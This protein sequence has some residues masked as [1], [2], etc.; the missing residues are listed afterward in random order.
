MPNSPNRLSQ[1]WQELKRRKV[2][3]VIAM[4]AATA[5]IIMEAAEI[6]LP[7]FGLP[8]WTVTFIIILLIVGFLITIIFSWIFDITPEGIKKTEPVEVVKETAI[9]PAK[10]RFRPS[11]VI[12]ALLVVIVVILAYPK[13]FKKDKSLF[14]KAFENKISIAVFPF[15][16]N[17]GDSA[18]DHLENGISE[19]LI[20]ALS[21]SD[22]LSVIDN[23]TINNVIDNVESLHIASIAPDMA[24]EVAKSV[25]VES[26]IDGNYLLAGSTFR[27]NLNLIDT[28]SSEVLKTDYVEG[29]ADSI[30]SM[31]GS[32]SNS[33]KN[34]LEI[35]AMGDDLNREKEDYVTTN[36]SKA[37]RYF[38]QGLEVFWEGTWSWHAREYFQKAIKIDSTF[39]SAYF[40][41]SVAMW[42][43]DTNLLKA[44]EGKDRLSMK[45]QLWLSAFMSKYIEKN[46][47]KTINYF[48]QAT[49]IDPISRLG[50]FFLGWHYERIEKYEDALL[51]LEQI[52]KLNKQLGPWKNHY[53]YVLLGNIYRYLEKYNKAQKIYKKGIQHFP[54]SWFIPMGQAKCALLQNDTISANHYIDQFKSAY[55]SADIP[56]E[57]LTLAFIGSIYKDAGQI[58]KAEE[59][60]RHSLEVRINQGYN[61]D[62][63]F[64]GNHLFWAYDILGRFLIDNDIN[65]EE[66]M[67]YIHEALELA[68]ESERHSDHPQ[69][70]HGLG[71]GYYKQGKYEEALQALKRAEE[72]TKEYDHTIHQRIKEVE[73]ALASQ[74]Q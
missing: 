49:E 71:W 72:G 41:L 34:Y 69:M 28:E 16:N 73:Q 19:L 60:Y 8:D 3:K 30:F 55:N 10:R 68:K 20:N 9:K 74:N 51:S 37:Y 31:V 44:Y 22:K 1:F 39:T 67:E 35:T 13:I 17:T 56:R 47:Y 58:K 65:V 32:F 63:T 21:T 70:L 2:I 59:L 54:D 27:I 26:Y 5:F 24:K 40:W 50:W 29:K 62:T 11:D 61:I 52:I 46:P 33:I 15:M 6:M 12:I 4:Y 23:Q 45:M 53:F 43:G 64:V 7:R 42:G 14:D 18:Y 25:K 48:K 57:T 38:I 66:G 36:S